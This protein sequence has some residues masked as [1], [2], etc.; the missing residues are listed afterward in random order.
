[1]IA[2][3]GGPPFQ[4]YVMPQRL[5]RDVLVGTTSIFFAVVNWV[6]VPP[7]IAL[8]LFTRETLLTSVALFPLAIAA[9][10]AG[11]LLVRR[12]SAENFS[13]IIYVLMMLIGVRLI[14][15]GLVGLHRWP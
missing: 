4:I 13:R 11:V 2:N 3:I 14:W 6:K 9:T 15:D 12:V 7:F 8:G 5:P 1:M 10:W